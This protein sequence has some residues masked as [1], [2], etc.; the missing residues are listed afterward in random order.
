M[1]A[2]AAQA[3]GIGCSFDDRVTQATRMIEMIAAVD[4]VVDLLVRELQRIFWSAGGAA[5]TN[6]RFQRDMLL[7]N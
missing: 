2:V 3:T 1:T 7:V 5:T 4:R 6:Q